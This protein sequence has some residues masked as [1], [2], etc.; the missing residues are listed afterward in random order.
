MAGT[1]AENQQRRTEEATRR[2]RARTTL[3]ESFRTN[4]KEDEDY[5]EQPLDPQLVKAF[6]NLW[7][8]AV[9]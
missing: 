6:E 8:H 1:P 3:H 2:R 5:T 4:D 7:D 9:T